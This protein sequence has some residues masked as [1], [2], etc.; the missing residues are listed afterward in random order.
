[1]KLKKLYHIPFLGLL[2]VLSLLFGLP[3]GLAKPDLRVHNVDTG[4]DYATIQEAID[5]N[6]TSNGHTIRVDAGIYQ[7]NVVV[8]KSIALIGGNRETTIIDGGAI[9]DVVRVS[10]HN[11]TISGF[12]MRNGYLKGIDVSNCDG[13]KITNNVISGNI[14]YGIQIL[15]SSSNTVTGNVLYSNSNGISL[16]KSS[17][18]VIRHNNASSNNA[19]G[20]VLSTVSESIVTEN[21]ASTNNWVGIYLRASSNNV[22][23][24]N[25]LSTN[26]RSGISIET[27]KIE[28]NIYASANNTFSSNNILNNPIGIYFARS[29]NNT[30]FNNNLVNNTQQVYDEPF[31]HEAPS[32]NIWEN[33]FP[34]GGNYWDNYAGADMLSGSH[35]NETGSDG[36]GDA[37]H[38]IN[39]YNQD[40]YPLVGIFSDF[41][42]SL[43]YHV[44]VISNSTIEDFEYF[45]SNSTILMH[46]SN[47]T[48]TQTSGFC[49]VCIPHTL[50]NSGKIS[51]II[52]GGQTP[53][54]Y[55]N[56]ALHDNSTH[57]WIYFTYEHS[58]HKVV[59][60]ESITSPI[61]SVLSPENKTY[62]VNDVHLSFT[63][64]EAT[65]WTGYSLDGQMK[66]TTNGNTTMVDLSDGTHT[67]TVYA[68]DTSGNMGASSTVYFAVDTAPPNIRNVSQ[69][70]PENNVLPEDEVKINATVSDD[71]SK[72]KQVILNYTNGNGTWIAIEMTNLEGN[73]WN[74]TTPAFPYGTNVSYIIMAEDSVGNTRTTEEMGYEYQYRVIPEFP[75][76]AITPLIIMAT[77]LLTIVN[78]RNALNRLHKNSHSTIDSEKND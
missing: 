75:A 32:M 7:E 2:L 3:G 28:N 41:N 38:I 30:F 9:R 55:H 11:V 22:V 26:K 14:G 78:G 52:D 58:T 48:T 66:V 67:I 12:T 69:I 36:I 16:Q 70:P 15:N 5:A 18:N 37:P 43:G 76:T 59:I 51:V 23:C 49:R 54:L 39:E 6:D 8:S 77:L 19:D 4:L 13:S 31:A 60:Q 71:V 45:E 57:R 33:D 65:A 46:V 20:I 40:R 64:S 27:V 25:S 29:S 24:S 44:N 73:I 74:A 47:T 53:I 17:S 21:I 56:Y 68:N 10:A 72:V 50:L 62:A 61:I 1:M 63:V 42:T 34:L 35:Q